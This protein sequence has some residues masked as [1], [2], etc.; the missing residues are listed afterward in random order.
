MTEN[1]DS[2]DEDT[3]GRWLVTT[4]GSTHVWDL[5]EMTY[6]RRPGPE[7]LAG[8]F[9]FDGTPMKITRVVQWP[10][11]GDQSAILYDDPDVPDAL[12]HYRISSQIKSIERIEV[13][14]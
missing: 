4:Q 13:A 8:S 7:S 3:G 5:D 9:R 14:E 1:R 6:V 11:V 2:L 10:K 12:E